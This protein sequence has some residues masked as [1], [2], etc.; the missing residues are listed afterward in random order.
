MWYHMY[1]S[2]GMTTK[3]M[4]SREV[5]DNWR[6][7]L[8]HVEAGGEVVIEH[9]N[10]PVARITP[11]EENAMTLRTYRQPHVHL[12]WVAKEEAMAARKGHGKFWI[13][14][15]SLTKP[16]TALLADGYI[17]LVPFEGGG[18]TERH[19]ELTDKGIAALDAELLQQVI[20][21]GNA[22]KR[23]HGATSQDITAE[24]VFEFYR[25]HTES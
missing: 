13:D 25:S 11:I 6:E 16:M 23:T 14:V 12:Q 2:R 9:Y 15:T 10:R 22:N 8:R 4:K 3:R 1:H 18:E 20:D 7:T 21:D 5:R 19:L 17:R 24:E